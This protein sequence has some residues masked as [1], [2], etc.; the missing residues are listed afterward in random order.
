MIWMSKHRATLEAEFRHTSPAWGVLAEYLADHGITD[1]LGQRPTAR[2]TREG[3]ARVKSVKPVQQAASS[4]PTVPSAVRAIA[5]PAMPEP[6]Q[7][8]DE[9]E[10]DLSQMFKVMRRPKKVE[11]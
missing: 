4:E 7:T 6:P 10:P 3:W 8:P 1:G 9:P 2:S 5:Q 11:E